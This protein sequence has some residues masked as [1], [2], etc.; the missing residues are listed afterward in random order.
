MPVQRRALLLG[1]EIQPVVGPGQQAFGAELQGFDRITLQGFGH[2]ALCRQIIGEQ[3]AFGADIKDP[4]FGIEDQGIDK[5]RGFV[6]SPVFQ[7]DWF[8]PVAGEVVSAQ[9][10]V[11]PDVEAFPVV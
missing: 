7:P 4:I 11:G 3:A 5:N 8:D 6:R 2:D 1:E 10:A 9:S